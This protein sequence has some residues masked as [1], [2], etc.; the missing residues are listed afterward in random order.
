M[1]NYIEVITDVS[2]RNSTL[3]PNLAD[4]LNFAPPIHVTVVIVVRQPVNGILVTYRL[5][6]KI[7]A[8]YMEE[9][10]TEI[11]YGMLEEG[12]PTEGRKGLILWEKR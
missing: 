3:D 8:Q 5:Q 6:W 7:L 12:V 9:E 11:G 2:C 1:S 10:K 4:R